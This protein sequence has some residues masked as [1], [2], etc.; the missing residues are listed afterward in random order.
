MLYFGLMMTVLQPKHVAYEFNY[1]VLTNLL[2]VCVVF[3]DGNKYHCTIITQRDG[4]YLKTLL[5]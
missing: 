4:S 3:L 1:N 2:I 5:V